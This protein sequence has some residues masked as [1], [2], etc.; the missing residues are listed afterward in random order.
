[1]KTICKYF[2]NIVIELIKNILFYIKK[3]PYIFSPVFIIGCGRSGTTILGSTLSHHPKLKYLNERRDL[4][5]RSYPEFDIWNKKNK[6]SK[7]YA[8]EK[9]IIFKQNHVLHRLLF[10]E[11]V[12]GNA[13]I[14]L[15]KLPINNFRLR[16]LEKSFPNARYIYLTRNGLEVSASIEKSIQKGD[17]VRN[18]DL[19]KSY[20]IENS[21]QNKGIWEWKLSIDQSD[22]FFK[23]IDR[24]RLKH[25]SYKDFIDSPAEIIKDIFNFLELD[26]TE[27]WINKISKNIKRKNP[28]IKTVADKSLYLIGGDILN[29]TINNKYTPF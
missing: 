17:W 16:F 8:D 13:K 27:D 26:Y 4:W 2:Y 24:G 10:R 18:Q 3:S 14:L 9:D 5:H 21:D 15:E 25:L 29:Q 20:N 11:Q 23:S 1:M 28:E 12:L 22:H 6:N 19:L 7:L